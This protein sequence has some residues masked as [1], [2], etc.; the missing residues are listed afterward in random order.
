LERT[1]TLAIVEE[2][3]KSLSHIQRLSVVL[4]VSLL[5][6]LAHAQSTRGSLGGLITDANGAA[7][8]AATVTVRNATTGE[9]F[10]SITD[11][12]GAYVFPSLPPGKYNLRVEATGFKRTE[13]QEIAVDVSTPAKVNV[14]IE[15]GA[16]SEAVVVTS[17]TQ[18]VVN[19]T[20][21]TL[22]NVITTRQVQDLPIAGRNPV[23]LARL[24]AGIAVPGNNT[25]QAS[26]GGLRGSATNVTQDGINAMDNSSRPT[27][28]LRSAP[29]RSIQRASSVSRSAQSPQMLGGESRRFEW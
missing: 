11:N 28:S 3:M 5:S 26:V 2:I 1:L 17:A 19:T 7:V 18:E 10:K 8:A 20:S 13:V 27:H 4:V 22:T 24:Q 15:V 16:V 25:R 9:D 29:R 6:L 21:P 12:E 14:S 23:D